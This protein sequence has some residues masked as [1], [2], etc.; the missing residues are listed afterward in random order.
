LDAGIGLKTKIECIE[1]H[2]IVRASFV[3]ILTGFP[4]YFF[5]ECFRGR[6]IS[7]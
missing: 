3:R 6:D 1:Q 7:V 4:P 2:V 5:E